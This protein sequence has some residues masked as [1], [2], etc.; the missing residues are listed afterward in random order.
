MKYFVSLYIRDTLCFSLK[1]V[2][3]TSL[4]WFTMTELSCDF[5]FNGGI[6]LI[7]PKIGYR[8]AIDPFILAGFVKVKSGMRVLD[9]G[10]GVG[11]ISLLLKY[12]DPTL[13]ILGIDVDPDFCDIFK[14]NAKLNKMQ[15][16]VIN[17]DIAKIQLDL[18]DCVVTNPPFYDASAARISKVKQQANFET[19]TLRSWILGCL[20]QLKNGGI[21]ALIHVAS[22]VDEIICILAR[23]VGNINIIP[24]FTRAGVPAKR[25]V[26][27]GIKG[28]RSEICITP[29]ITVHNVD[30]SYTE[31]V[32][33]MLFDKGD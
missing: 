28:S 11:T 22:R 9:V 3:S 17:G 31:E 2:Y 29:G 18:F 15:I 21:F 30:G 33:K 26:I 24:I 27:T 12:E 25:V 1:Y 23:R 10:C 14:Q 32:K 5:I 8:V 16:G 19:I 4:Y 6:R 13:D 7:Q 20:K